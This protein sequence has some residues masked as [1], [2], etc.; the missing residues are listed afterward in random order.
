MH[1]PWACDRLLDVDCEPAVES[2][3]RHVVNRHDGPPRLQV[4][5][6]LE[7]DRLQPHE[8]STIARKIE[9]GLGKWLRPKV[10]V[11]NKRIEKVTKTPLAW[12]SVT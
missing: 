6:G 9:A 3:V 8:A 10:T 5:F 1:Q 4:I 7:D 2:V 12:L 11:T